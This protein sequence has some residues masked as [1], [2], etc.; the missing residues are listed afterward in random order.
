MTRS[1]GPSD[2]AGE[3]TA[4]GRGPCGGDSEDTTGQTSGDPDGVRARRIILGTYHEGD[5]LKERRGSPGLTST[6]SA[7][8]GR[9]RTGRGPLGAL[10]VLGLGGAIPGGEQGQPQCQGRR[11]GGGCVRPTE[12]SR[13]HLPMR[14]PGSTLP[15]GGGQWTNAAQDESPATFRPPLYRSTGQRGPTPPTPTARHTQRAAA[16]PSAAAHQAL[17]MQAKPSAINYVAAIFA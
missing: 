15:P 16:M 17:Q 11:R 2:S 3:R 8:L 12:T 5:L 6:L 7:L 14:S 9:G 4:R 10:G 13:V 1:I